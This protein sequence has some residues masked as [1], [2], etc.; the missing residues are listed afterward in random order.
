MSTNQI[1][2]KRIARSLAKRRLV[3]PDPRRYSRPREL[4]KATEIGAASYLSICGL[5]DGA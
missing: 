3:K 1:I 2:P 4:S 5:S